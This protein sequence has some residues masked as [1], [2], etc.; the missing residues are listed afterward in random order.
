MSEILSAGVFIEEV[1]SSAQVIQPV[2][3]SN[4]GI[5]GF[6]PQGPTDT[7][8]LVGSFDEFTRVFGPAVK[9]SFMGLAMFAYFSNG[10]RRAFVV[11]VMPSDAVAADAF[12]ESQTTDQAIF[13]GDGATNA[14]LATSGTTLFKVNAGASPLVPSSISV[15]WR[16]SATGVTAEAT[17]QRD[18]TT[19][20]VTSNIA[21]SIYYEG[22]LDPANKP[23]YDEKL[24]RVGRGTVIIKWDAGAKVVAISANTMIATGTTGDGTVKIDHASGRFSLVTAATPTTTGA[25]TA[26]YTP[27]E[28]DQGD[29]ASATINSGG[30]ANGK[31]YVIVDAIGA[32]GNAYTFE[33]IDPA[34]ALNVPLSA[35]YASGST[36]AI[37]VTLATDGAGVLDAAANTATLVAAAVT[38][39][40]RVTASESGTGATALAA[41]ESTTAFTGGRDAAKTFS[42]V[43][44]GAT[45]L[46]ATVGL[47][48]PGTIDYTT[49]AYS[50]TT[51]ATV[52]II[53]GVTSSGFTLVTYA[54]TPINHDSLYASYEIKAWHMHP[55]SKGAWAN[56]LRLR[57]TGNADFYTASTATYSQFNVAVQ[58]LNAS[59]TFDTLETFEEVDFATPTA[60]NFWA[61]VINE[62][63]DFITVDEPGGNEPPLQLNGVARVNVVAGGDQANGTRQITTT[64]SPAPIAPRSVSIS[65]TDTTGAAKVVTDDGNG[66]M[67]GDIDVAGTNTIVYATGVLNVM[68]APS[69][70]IKGGTLVT[71]SYESAVGETT[72]TEDFGDTTKG[73][74][75]GSDGT[76]TSTT[77]GRSQFT[78]PLLEPGSTGIFALNK[79]DELMQV[80][81]P[82]F[83]GDQ[84]VTGDL[85]DMAETRATQPSGADRFLILQVPQGSSPQ[86]AV[87]WLRFTLARN[88]IHGALYWPWVRVADPL[89]NGRPLTMPAVGHIAGVYARTDSNRNVGKSPGGTVDGALNFLLGLETI[90]TQADRDFVYPNRINPLIS[91]PQTGLAV[92]GVRTMA[93]PSQSEWRYI[94]ARRLFNFLE[95]S[96][97]NATAWIVFENNGPALWTRIASQ[98]NGFLTAMFNDGLF[99]GRTPSE[100]FFVIVDS[101]N[102]TAASID[103]GQVIIDV[104]VA[105][106]R[107]AEF[108]RFRFAQKTLT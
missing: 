58:Q 99:A 81:L 96:I 6:T 56:D 51:S 77:Y 2:S 83:V 5:A 73:Y 53:T 108:V 63:S 43:D 78:S 85:I 68:V 74:T 104:G 62:L 16:G 20:L 60:S 105:P 13:A 27:A 59:S 84:V 49:G 47:T 41:A 30:G 35:A 24:G 88:T 72:H 3:T 26:D 57:V 28:G 98:L 21:G 66:N 31:V 9:Q 107:P 97:F 37:I 70:T 89:S 15:R 75:A 86:E 91:S 82:D 69:S 87:D 92:W 64:L 102:N 50:F 36:T 103:L 46:T 4:M 33:V 48:A 42:L 34:P 38:A 61:D 54:A 1:P 18:G 10:G 12:V 44:D 39:L 93:G 71:V 14:I 76:F 7:A 106:N 67:I 32:A 90:T 11:R 22:M 19:G 100:A 29:R 52:T 80:V 23:G 94:S 8:T 101:S 65:Y 40:P 25:I 45:A 79:V 55:I 17:K 95:K